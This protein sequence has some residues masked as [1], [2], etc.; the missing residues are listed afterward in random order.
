[1]VGEIGHLTADYGALFAGAIIALECLCIPVPGETA[2]LTAAIYDGATHDTGIWWVFVAGVL[3]A[4][5]GNFAAFW[6]GR[7]FGYK[8]LLQYG[9]RIH[10][11]RSRLKIGQ[12]LFMRHGG[13]FVVFAR[14]VPVL[15]SFAGVL[16]GANFMN[17]VRFSAANVVGAIVWVG[18]DCFGAYYLGKELV[19]LTFWVGIGVAGIV[20][21]LAGGVAIVV[22]QQES[23][24]GP[25][26]EQALSEQP[27]RRRADSE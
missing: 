14:F 21:P 13:K 26:A 24:L 6:L 3:G 23:R 17:A 1:M 22:A 19:K 5:C 12:Y 25:D 15:R 8:F 7:R 11:S 27:G 16:A 18:V 10:L 4:V 9:A 2:L 20:L